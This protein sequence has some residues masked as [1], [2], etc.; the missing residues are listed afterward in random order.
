MEHGPA[1]S[2]LARW[3]LKPTALPTLANGIAIVTSSIASTRLSSPALAYASQEPRPMLRT[4]RSSRF[5]RTHSS[6][7]AS[8]IPSSSPNHSSHIRFSATLSRPATRTVSLS[9]RLIP[10]RASVRQPN[11]CLDQPIVPVF[12]PQREIGERSRCIRHCWCR[13]AG[14]GGRPGRQASAGPL[15]SGFECSSFYLSD[16]STRYHGRDD[17]DS[18]GSGWRCDCLR[19]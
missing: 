2:N 9:L 15:P 4:S 3:P 8:S 6:S 7:V 10:T 18:E 16:A 12:H 14:V 5:P 13:G 19:D 11:E 17:K 1:S